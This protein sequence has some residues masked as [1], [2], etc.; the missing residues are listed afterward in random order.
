MYGLPQG[1]GKAGEKKQEFSD[2]GRPP[3]DGVFLTV[4]IYLLFCSLRRST[5]CFANSIT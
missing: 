5:S 4:P 3:P 1:Y 2:S